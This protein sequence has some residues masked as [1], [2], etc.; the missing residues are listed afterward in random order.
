MPVA[1]DMNSGM[2][3]RLRSLPI[4]STAVLTGTSRPASS[5]TRSR[6]RS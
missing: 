4:A 3:D 2:I 6:R 5:A 1:D